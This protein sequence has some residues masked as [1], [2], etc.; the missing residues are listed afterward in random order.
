[1]TRASQPIKR[2][3]PFRD[4]RLV[5][6]AAEGAKTEKVYFEGLQEY[7]DSTRLQLVFLERPIGREGH[8][9]PES[10]LAQLREY[11]R[12]NELKRDD[13]MWFVVDTDRWPAHKL[14]EVISQAS[15]LDIESGLSCPC[16]EVFLVCH[17]EDITNDSAIRVDKPESTPASEWKTRLGR[18]CNGMSAEFRERF[19][20]RLE[21]AVTN[22]RRLSPNPPAFFPLIGTRAHLLLEVALT[23][24]DR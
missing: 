23:F 3:K 7:I 15:R 13:Q 8:S 1:M 9:S 21:D 11:R 6:I 24:R 12:K 20:P 17:F 2:R 14:A 16:F 4:A 18:H 22:A 19:G 10:V 5:V